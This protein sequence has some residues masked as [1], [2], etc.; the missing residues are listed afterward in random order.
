MLTMRPYFWAMR[1]CPA[2]GEE[3]RR[4]DVRV[5]LACIPPARGGCFPRPR[6]LQNVKS[7]EFADRRSD[8]ANVAGSVASAA[9]AGYGSER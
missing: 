7:A 9:I 2:T 4:F 5:R 3:K 6:C 1:W 8:T